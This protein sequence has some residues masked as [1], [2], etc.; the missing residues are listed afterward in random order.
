MRPR[1][2]QALPGTDADSDVKTTLRT[3]PRPCFAGD[4]AQALA[5]AG[6]PYSRAPCAAL[7]TALAGRPSTLIFRIDQE[8][9]P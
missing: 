6:E 8:P 7:S 2:S 9:Q 5:F 3:P 1:R 4:T